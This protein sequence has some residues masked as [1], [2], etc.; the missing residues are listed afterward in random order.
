M[1]F[2]LTQYDG[3]DSKMYGLLIDMDGV[4][5]E[6]SQFIPGADALISA[7]HTNGF[8]IVDKDPDYVVGEGRTYP[9]R[10]SSTRP[11]SSSAGCS[12]ATT[13]SS[14]SP[15]VPNEKTWPT[16]PT[17]RTPLSTRS[18]TSTP[19]VSNA[20]SWASARRLEH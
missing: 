9:S 7:M 15:A 1:K 3:K 5:Y 14:F 19:T 20:C 18:R 17:S 12:S 6:S 2:K 13:P 10:C 8:A 16:T 11:T 4:I